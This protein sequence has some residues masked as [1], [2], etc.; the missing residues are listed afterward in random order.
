MSQETPP[1]R[2]TGPGQKSAPMVPMSAE[3][4]ARGKRKNL[5]VW[6]G[7][8]LLAILI[9]WWIYRSSSSSQEVQKALNDGAQLLRATR[10][11]DAIQSFDP[12]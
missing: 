8:G 2:E 12:L 1:R 9:G 3:D 6:S 7:I 11:T 5:Y 4:F 10:Y